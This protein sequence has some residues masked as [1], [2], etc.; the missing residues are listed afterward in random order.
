MSDK[1]VGAI[2]MDLNGTDIEVASV[3]HQFT[4]GRVVVKTMNRTGQ[5]AGT[6]K[7]IADHTLRVSVPIPKTSEPNWS[8]V[9]DAKITMEPGD[10]GGQ[11][12][13]WTGVFLISIGSKYQVE[14]EA[15]RDLEMGALNYYAE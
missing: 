8:A 3:D 9:L 2:V 5:A 4:T 1:Y 11:R 7:G 12:E 15:M 13:T 6:A 10:G 14:G